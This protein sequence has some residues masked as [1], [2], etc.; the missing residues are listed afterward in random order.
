MKRLV[1]QLA[2]KA[3]RLAFWR[4]PAAAVPEQVVEA[5]AEAPDSPAEPV[6]AA[7]QIAW[8]ARIMKRLSG[9]PQDESPSSAEGAEATEGAAATAEA[10]TPKRSMLAL[11]SSKRVWIPAVSAVVLTLI[12][13]MAAMLMQSNQEKGQLQARLAETEKALKNKPPEPAPQPIEV[14]PLLKMPDMEALPTEVAMHSAKDS[15]PVE[16]TQPEEARQ[17]DDT[18]PQA[19]AGIKP[20][21]EPMP[22]KASRKP[23]MSGECNISSQ[24]NVRAS[25]KDCIDA[26]NA[27]S[28]R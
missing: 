17:P 9:E 22:E 6:P 28:A 13:S 1:E 26:F 18:K 15:L 10:E 5:V 7:P 8:M 4:K 19:Q 23:A 12:A 2:R 16:P 3:S 27:L 24:E 14:P 11:L 25:L 21:A 20:E